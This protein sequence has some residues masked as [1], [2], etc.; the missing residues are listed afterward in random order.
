[1]ER[2]PSPVDGSPIRSNNFESIHEN[3]ELKQRL[4]AQFPND[5]DSYVFG[6]TDFVLEVLRVAGLTEARLNRAR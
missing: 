6:K 3:G 4:A 2:C 1:V 5:I